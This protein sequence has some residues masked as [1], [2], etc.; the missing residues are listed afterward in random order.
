METSL[1]IQCGIVALT[2]RKQQFLNAEYDNL[3]H[4]LQTKEDL[5]LH[6][7]NK[8]QTQRFYKVVKAG[9]EYPISVRRDLLK[10]KRVGNKVSEYWAKIP[11]KGTRR[12]WVAIK[13]HRA[14]PENFKIC[15][16]KLYRRNGRFYLNVVVKGEV[17]LNTSFRKVLAVD[18][19][20]KTIAT[21]VLLCNGQI[22]HPHFYGKNVRG[23]RRHYAWLRKRL[24]ERKALKTIRKVGHTEKRKVNAVLHKIS[25]AIV[26]EA[27][28][29]NAVIVIGNP[30]GIRQRARGKGK[31]FN[32]I[33][34][35]M[36]FH[37]L[38]MMIE[39]KAIQQ[40]ILVVS[41]S[42]AYTSRN[43]HVCGCDGERKS[44]GLF[45]CRHCGEYNAD[46]NGAIN[47][48]KKFERDLGYMPLSGVACEPALNSNCS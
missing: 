28:R 5:G 47:I 12:L 6:S 30:C 37:R 43:C 33:V 21:T 26:E 46:L 22:S 44:Q 4:F 36:P 24:G 11:V 15:E 48:G 17:A 19:G 3:Q 29:E 34:S 9:K 35:N 45:V 10:I 23:I 16:S 41:T 14:F 20:E 2:K 27:Q 31:R 8:Q 38:S 32:R 13:P 40:G 7:A 42:E 25:K 18:L 1:T 39:Y